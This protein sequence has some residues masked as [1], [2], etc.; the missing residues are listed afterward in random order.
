MIVTPWVLHEVESASRARSARMNPAVGSKYV[1]PVL[2]TRMPKRR[3]TSSAS[4]D[5]AGTPRLTSASRSL[6]RS[7]P[8]VSTPTGRRSSD[9][10]SSS[11]SRHR[12]SASRQS[13]IHSGAG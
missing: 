8:C 5:V 9:P 7:L 12:G 13:D 6:R 4:T 3:S 10:V 2:G 1:S 11:S